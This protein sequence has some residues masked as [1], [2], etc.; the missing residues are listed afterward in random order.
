[1]RKAL[2]AL[3]FRMPSS[4]ASEQV[5]KNKTLLARVKPNMFVAGG[6]VPIIVNDNVIGAIGVSGAGGAVIGQQ[7]ESCAMAGLNRIRHRL[8]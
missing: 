5:N 2:T 6:A 1:M 7:D 8:K 3:A 4:E